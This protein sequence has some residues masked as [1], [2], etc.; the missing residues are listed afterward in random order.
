MTDDEEDWKVKPELRGKRITAHVSHGRE[1]FR[2]HVVAESAFRAHIEYI[3]DHLCD[4]SGHHFCF[5]HTKVWQWADAASTELYAAPITRAQAE[6]LSWH[7]NTWT[8]L[9]EDD[10][11]LT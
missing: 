4:W 3:T 6:N 8:W 1:G 7:H 10:G 11:S 5:L 2:L 9:D